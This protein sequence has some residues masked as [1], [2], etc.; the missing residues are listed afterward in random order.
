MP[1]VPS[2]YEP[3]Q[4]IKCLVIK[5]LTWDLNIHVIKSILHPL[6]LHPTIEQSHPPLTSSTGF[7]PPPPLQSGTSALWR[8]P[9]GEKPRIM[10]TNMDFIN[11]KELLENYTWDE[12][13]IIVT[14][15]T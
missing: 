2:Q 12:Y 1:Q 14:S 13:A 4:S 5:D 8:C 3:S 15:L 9:T 10:A 11:I 6:G 7:S